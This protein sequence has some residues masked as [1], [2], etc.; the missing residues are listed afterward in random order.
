MPSENM[1]VK[2]VPDQD[3]IKMLGFDNISDFMKDGFKTLMEAIK[4][5]NSLPQGSDWNFYHAHETFN[6]I[7]N[8]ESGKVLKQ[9]NGILRTNH[10]EGN[11]RN[12]CLEEKTDLIV[13]GNDNILERVANDI[14]EMNG[15]KKAG[16]APVLIQ[17]V[18]AE[19]PINGSW[20]R[21]NDVK[22]SVTPT[23]T[24]QVNLQD[25]KN[26]VTLI[27]AKNVI[28]PQKFFR[29]KIINSSKFPWEP[30]I[31][32]KPNSIKPLA[33]F[34]EETENGEEYSHPYE[35]ELDRFTPLPIQ[36]KKENPLKPL[37]VE[38]T[39]LIEITEEGQLDE[40]V[41]TL[42]NC[43][44]FAVDVEHHSY[45]TFM[46]ITCLLQISTR[47]KDYI[48]DALALR[49]KLWVLNEAFTKPTIIKIFHGADSDI[50]WLQR[51]LSIYV[52]NMFDTY[53]AAKQLEISGLSLAYLM[54]RYCS[55]VPNKQF[56]LADWRI[57][58]LP[59]ELK[60]YARE[61][62][63]HLIY[64]YQMLKNDLLKKANGSDNLLLAVIN[65]STET[66]KKR[67]FRPVLRD[68]SHLDFYRKCKRHFDN[69]QLYALKQI[70]KWRDELAREE[71]ESIGYVL[72]NHMLLQIAE[73]LPREMQGVLACC[74][75]I[76]PLVKAN[77]LEIHQIILRA[78]EQP[79]EK[80]IFKEDTRA[81]GSTKKISKINVDSPLNCPHDLTKANEFR[82]DLPTILG[83]NSPSLMNLSNGKLENE[84]DKPKCSVFFTPDNS[85]DEEKKNKIN[86]KF[87]RPFERYKL[88]RSYIQ[89]EEE[90]SAEAEN[91]ENVNQNQEE[92][93]TMTDEQ[94][95]EEIRQHFLKLSKSGPVAPEPELSLVQM[96]GT[97]RKRDHSPSVREQ[98]AS[99]HP[100]FLSMSREVTNSR[101]D[102]N[103]HKRKSSDNADGAPPDKIRN[104]NKHKQKQQRRKAVRE[105]E[106]RR[107][108]RNEESEENQLDGQNRTDSSTRS[109]EFNKQH[110]QKRQR[111]KNK[112]KQKKK[113]QQNQTRPEN[114]HDNENSEVDN[115]NSEVDNQNS[116]VEFKPF[117]YSS[118]DFRQFQGGAG[119]VSKPQEVKSTIRFKKQ[120]QGANKN[121][122]KSAFFK[123][124]GGKGG[125][126]GGGRGGGG[127][128]GGGRGG[129]GARGGGR[130]G[131]S[132]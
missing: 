120:K 114:G 106:Q 54:Q 60:Q 12:R 110:Q 80:P 14:D 93:V 1:E 76:P 86:F 112:Q 79:L 5:S 24:P 88:V 44:E 25:P 74:N 82:D 119:S 22:F 51:D 89:A 19:L 35:F 108:M 123:H 75:P 90:K 47:E 113:F 62:T 8:E 72:P 101:G 49:D 10:I 84:T 46:G 32:I 57:R 59:D 85:E 99:V 33:I 58:P 109:H 129:G 26:T 95:I 40:L 63:H 94:R 116:E 28:R 42:L 20:N 29:D 7:M 98:S 65:N 13:E 36:L 126:R 55:F 3:K 6:K 115:Q 92:V 105:Q 83:N 132:Y 9:I 48:I 23:I 81:R 50:V 107:F 41:E 34:L 39:P 87:L 125:H 102:N 96:G 70:Y 15:I 4:H 37:P 124:I 61:D 130:P 66:C 128:G 103:I 64:I 68:D 18:S 11:V 117:D 91:V 69:R 56:Q 21:F 97:K 104:T 43:Q 111:F 78:K 17:N 121:N 30:R 31:K 127:R 16:V 27:A 45:R 2:Q 53:Q 77:L 122:N 73:T 100:V 131:R 71:D 67:Y 38:E 52:V 118:V